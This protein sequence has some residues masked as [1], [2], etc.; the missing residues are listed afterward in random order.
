MEIGGVTAFYYSTE[1]RFGD[2]EIV[3][4]RVFW[5][6]GEYMY[7]IYIT[8]PA[9]D[10]DTIFD[11]LDSVVFTEINPNVVGVLFKEPIEI[12]P[13]L[14]SVTSTSLGFTMDIPVGWTRMADNT[15]F[16]SPEM[17]IVVFPLESPVDRRTVREFAENY[18]DIY[19]YVNIGE[20]VRIRAA[21]L[22]S[23]A[24]SGYV[25][26]ISVA[27]DSYHVYIFYHV[28]NASDTAFIIQATVHEMFNSEFA[29]DFIS[30]IVRSFVVE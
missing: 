5:D 9:E 30:D 6:Y 23:N 26:E 20:P 21:D 25:L 8:V 15:I 29:R 10:E 12:E 16:F 4:R 1:G 28:I 24:L 14:T 2:V 11:I 3:N 19:D 27:Y 13:V 22:S 7:C 17:S 18:Y